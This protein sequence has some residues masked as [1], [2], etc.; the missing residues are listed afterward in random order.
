[1]TGQAISRQ[2]K[3]ICQKAQSD[4]L[5]EMTNCAKLSPRVL[6][7]WYIVPKVL[8]GAARPSTNEG[9]SSACAGTSFQRAGEPLGSKQASAAITYLPFSFYAGSALYSVQMNI[10]DCVAE[11]KQKL[12]WRNDNLDSR[13]FVLF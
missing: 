8:L 9:H 10:C 11:S 7:S 5:R 6:R 4:I 13:L 12:G 1:M 3:T 2:L